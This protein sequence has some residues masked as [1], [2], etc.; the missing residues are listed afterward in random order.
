MKERPIDGDLE[1]L[2]DETREKRDRLQQHLTVYQ[3]LRVQLETIAKLAGKPEHDK[4]MK[5]YEEYINLVFGSRRIRGRIEFENG[6]DKRSNGF[7]ITTRD[8]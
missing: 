2:L 6:H 1:Q 5:D 3:N 8:K 7:Q 4:V